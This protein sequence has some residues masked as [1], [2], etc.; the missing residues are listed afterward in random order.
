MAN[1]HATRMGGDDAAGGADVR[2]VSVSDGRDVAYAEYGDS[3][4]VPV[5]FL[6]GTPGS[7]LLGEI[8]DERARR[9][10][11][12]LL[13]LDRPGYGRSDPWPART[14]S[15][16]GSFVTAVLDD[17]GVSR[18][19]VVGFSGGGPHALAVA[20]THG[21]RVQRV[22]VVAGAVPPSRR[23]SPPLALR[24]LEILASATPTLARGLSRLQ[25]VLVARSDP[26]A[27]VSQYTDSRDADGISSAV[28]ELVKRDF[29]EAL[30][31]HRSGFVAETRTL[32]REWDF[33]M[34]NVTS[35][36]QLWHGGRDSNVPV[37]GAQRLAEQLPDATLTVLD[38]ADHLRTLLQSG[39]RILEE[40]GRESDG[41]EIESVEST[42]NAGHSASRS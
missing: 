37:E 27:V 20:A 42:S 23:E 17:A 33:S 21:E 16:T 10:G 3:D 35:A 13:A 30:A 2:T 39:D 41:N 15:D 40:Y 12:R 7:R 31:N 1:G 6:H 29:V 5:V 25:S 38:D 4:G 24:V 19:G 18:A 28:S 26:S 32:A 14:L 8:F 9:D 34:G 22:D 36:V 11:V